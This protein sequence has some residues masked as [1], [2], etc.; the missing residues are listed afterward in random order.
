MNKRYT[1]KDSVE[2]V[3]KGKTKLKGWDKSQNKTAR[4]VFTVLWCVLEFSKLLKIYIISFYIFWPLFEVILLKN[5][6]FRWLVRKRLF[7]DFMRQKYV[8]AVVV[9]IVLRHQNTSLVWKTKVDKEKQS[10]ISWA[11]RC[12]SEDTI[13]KEWIIF[14]ILC[15]FKGR[16]IFSPCL[17]L[18]C[19][20]IC[21]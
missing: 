11:K 15:F 5:D 6:S 18:K 1:V 9:F 3:A 2:V 13:Q 7:T 19:T 17:F 14:D 4:Y 8:Y 21:T 10:V 16:T 20:T 12:W